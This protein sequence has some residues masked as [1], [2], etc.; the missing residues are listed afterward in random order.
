MERIGCRESPGQSVI[1]QYF[2]KEELTMSGSKF[3]WKAGLAILGVVSL[4]AGAFAWNISTAATP[5][6]NPRAQHTPG[7]FLDHAH[8]AASPGFTMPAKTG[9]YYEINMTQFPQ[10]L[11]LRT[12]LNATTPNPAGAP[13]MT[14]VWGYGPAPGAPANSLTGI[15]AHY[16]SM[17]I[18]AKKGTPITVKWINN[19]PLTHLFTVDRSLTLGGP[20]VRTVVHVHGGEVQALYDGYPLYWFTPDARRPANGLGGPAGNFATYN[21]PNNQQA[22]TVWYHDHAMGVTRLN[23]YAGLAGFYLIRDPAVEAAFKLPNNSSTNPPAPGGI[24]DAYLSGRLEYELAFAIQ[25]KNFK[26]NGEQFYSDVGV[27]PSIHP[28]ANPELFGDHMLV[29]GTL[30]PHYNVEPRKYRVRLLNGSQAR[31]FNLRLENTSG[32]PGNAL[33]FWVIGTEGGYLQAPAQVSNLLIMPGERY[34]VIMDFAAFTN[35]TTNFILKNDAPA[36]L[37]QTPDPALTIPGYTTEIMQFQVNLPKSV[38]PDNPLPASFQTITPIAQSGAVTRNIVMAEVPG[39]NG[40]IG[41]R[42]NNKGLMDPIT[43]FPKV[44]STEI[45]R[46]INTTVDNHPMHMHLVQFQ[47][48]DRIPYNATGYKAAWT[49]AGKPLNFDPTPFYTGAAQ[50]PGVHERGWK[51]TVVVSPNFVTRVIS[52]YVGTPGPGA[53]FPGGFAFDVTQGTYVYH[54]HILDHEENDMMRPF[55][56]VP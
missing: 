31:S 23:A 43:E 49:A 20:D 24:T 2:E 29:N 46:W 39:I 26:Q 27:N 3:P 41:L 51:D 13:M 40:P 38:V 53:N 4:I 45:W 48:L 5:L 12:P 36:P 47:I 6:M 9:N 37:G 17:T 15:R 25:D 44:G 8:N 55:K 56:M 34:D 42:L 14:K 21:Y 7:V 50:L 1:D 10:W 11:G 18:E 16:P 33:P 19:L 32:A 54:C 30:W 22:G 28:L 52:K 35:L